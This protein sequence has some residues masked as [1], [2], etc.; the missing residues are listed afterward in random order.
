VGS[1]DAHA[2]LTVPLGSDRAEYTI[3]ELAAVRAGSALPA[4]RVHLAHDP[5]THDLRVVG[6]R[7]GEP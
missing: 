6:I 3:V 7:R 1:P 2:C 4:V 5:V